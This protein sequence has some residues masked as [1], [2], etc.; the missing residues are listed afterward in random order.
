V[1]SWLIPSLGLPVAMTTGRL[2][3]LT[4]TGASS[5]PRGSVIAAAGAALMLSLLLVMVG[6]RALGG[7]RGRRASRRGSIS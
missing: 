5:H 4:L 3:V 7:R 6:R 2:V 1:W